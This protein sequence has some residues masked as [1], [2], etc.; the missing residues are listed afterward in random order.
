MGARTWPRP[1]ISL[2]VRVLPMVA[3]GS[4]CGAPARAA[5]RRMWT[6]VGRSRRTGVCAGP[7][8]AQIA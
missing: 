4:E 8:T 5:S 1:R 2:V 7:G 3:V 6:G